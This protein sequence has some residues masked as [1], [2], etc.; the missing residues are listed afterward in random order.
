MYSLF[1]CLIVTRQELPA[2][3]F[4][5]WLLVKPNV[6]MLLL[7]RETSNIYRHRNQNN[8]KPNAKRRGN[9]CQKSKT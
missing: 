8:H 2:S 3:D 1:F 4:Y 9:G 7:S 6:P 5:R